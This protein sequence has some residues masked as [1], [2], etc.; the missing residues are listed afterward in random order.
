[1]SPSFE[2]ETIRD[3]L[4]AKIESDGDKR[5]LTLYI[6]VR[7]YVTSNLQFEV[8]TFV[9]DKDKKGYVF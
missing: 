7:S 9:Y 8:V 1:M 2:I 5:T 6:L 4:H 3:S